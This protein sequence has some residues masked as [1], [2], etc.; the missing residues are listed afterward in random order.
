MVIDWTKL[1]WA[2]FYVEIES[3]VGLNNPVNMIEQD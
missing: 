1:I 2:W 3:E